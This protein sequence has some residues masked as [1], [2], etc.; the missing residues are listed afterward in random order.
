MPINHS[1][2]NIVTL[3]LSLIFVTLIYLL[4]NP[5][6]KPEQLERLHYVGESAGRMMDRHLDFY[7]GYE[8]VGEIERYL[9]R[10]LFGVQTEVETQSLKNYEEVLAF[11]KR[12]PEQAT[13]WS[14][15][16]TQSRLLVVLAE[17]G[18]IESLRKNL[19]E[20]NDSPEAEM[21]AE[22]IR[23]AYLQESNEENLPEIM[24]GARMMPLGWAAD[25]LWIRI[26]ERH[27]DNVA[28]QYQLER[29][30]S[31]GIKQRQ[32]VLTVSVLVLIILLLG[33]FVLW[34]YKE[35]FTSTLWV[36]QPMHWSLAEG[37]AIAIRAAVAGMLI[38][39]LLHLWSTQYFKPGVL[40]LW[41]TLFASL[42]MVYLIRRHLK[43]RPA[44][45]MG[46]VF[47]LSLYGVGWKR[48]V[49]ICLGFLTV[50]WLGSMLISWLSWMIGIS[51]HWS[52]S[53]NERLVFG[54]SMTMWLGM[55]N[56]VIFAAVFEELGF[57]GLVYGTM[58]S[59]LNAR[60]AIV[61]SAL[62]FSSLHLYSLAGFLSVLWSGVVLAYMYERYR[63]LLPGMVVHGIGNLFSYG[64]VLLFYT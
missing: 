44:V 34:R 29:H 46:Q 58:R 63:S 4:F 19:A 42:P 52:E 6:S 10:F 7:A 56:L 64:T 40:A 12:R 51:S 55:I 11:F 31:N 61:I 47:G 3:L 1:H 14:I 18:R 33:M 17:T 43:Q 20:F 37:Y 24:Y 22:A 23:Y 15:L 62:L 50:D 8:Q 2:S 32:Q 41:S 38:M 53:I 49:I 16:N 27:G 9:H 60:W 25:R 35:V 39:L 59:R 5:F 13:S 57:R 45:S 36:H 28:L 21:V 48:F 26:A 54:P 30:L